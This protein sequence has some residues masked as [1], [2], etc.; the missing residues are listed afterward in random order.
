MSQVVVAPPEAPSPAAQAWVEM[1]AEGWRAP[2]DPD[3][4]ADHFI[5]WL[6]PEIRLL[7]PQMPVLVGYEA[8]REGFVRPMFET[9]PGLHGEVAGWGAR[10]DIVYIEVRLRGTLG[11]RPVEFTSCDRIILRGEKAIERYAYSDPT[12]LLQAGLANPRAWP[13][14]ARFQRQQLRNRRRFR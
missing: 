3:S 12:P 10:G 9:F 11:G 13:A 6:H 7:Q 2:T 4:F 8:F 1:F 5:P 14:L